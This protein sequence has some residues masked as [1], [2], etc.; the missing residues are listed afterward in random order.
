MKGLPLHSVD[1]IIIILSLVFPVII[2]LR[3]S[4][5]Q[6][7]SLNF[8][9]AGGTIPSWAIGIS[10]LAT[11]ISSVTF[12]AYPGEGFSS[13]WILL[14]QGL[15]VPVTLVFFIGFVVPLYRKVI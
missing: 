5:R 7:S 15:M 12:L 9:T 8:F 3:F 11:L 4:G 6:K 13:N 2:S 10:I 1:Y 14:V